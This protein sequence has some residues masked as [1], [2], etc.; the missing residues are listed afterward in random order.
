MDTETACFT[1]EEVKVGGNY[2]YGNAIKSID[3]TYA[4]ASIS[5]KSLM[6]S[7]SFT[8]DSVTMRITAINGSTMD[9]SRTYDA[10]EK[11]ITNTYD[12]DGVMYFADVYNDYVLNGLMIVEL[13]DVDDLATEV[14]KLSGGILVPGGTSTEMGS[15]PALVVS[16]TDYFISYGGL[17]VVDAVA[18]GN[19]YVSTTFTT[20]ESTGPGAMTVN[21]NTISL[22]LTGVA[23]GVFVDKDGVVTYGLLALP[24]YTLSENMTHSGFTISDCSDKTA[25]ITITGTSVSCSAIPDKYK[26][27]IDGQVVKEDVGYGTSVT[28][29]TVDPDALYAVDP[30]GTIIGNISSGT[31]NLGT[32]YY[33]TSDLNL[34]T[35]KGVELTTVSTEAINN[36]EAEAAKFEVPAGG[37]SLQFAMSSKV[38]F[39]LSGLTAGNTID[40]VAQ[41]TTYDGKDAFVIKAERGGFAL[42]STLYIPVSG[43]GNKLM[44]VDEYGRVTQVKADNVVVGEQ[45][46]LKA[47]VTDYSIFYAEADKPAY[48][49]GGNGGNGTN[50]LLIGGIVAVVAV[51]AIAGAVFFIKKH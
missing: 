12:V 43:D 41:Q 44:H 16:G 49:D 32:L 51:V 34:T 19:V 13:N 27:S 29:V 5:V 30:Y 35:V 10:T 48:D 46:Y 31:W 47:T 39:D 1:A 7:P 45:N 18:P 15:N 3:G 40:L 25:T 11:V 37:S 17:S 20:G 22:N 21:D 8:A 9:F 2:Y 6:S 4:N 36:V 26:I 23:V 14:N 33:F 28:G 38:R 50:W 42:A 24:G